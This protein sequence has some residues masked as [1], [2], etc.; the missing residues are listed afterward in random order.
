MPFS[1][2]NAAIL[3]GLA[4]GALPILIHLFSRRKVA[5]M[6]FSSLRFLEQISRRRVRRVRLTQWIILA[7]RVLAIVLLALALSRPAFRGDFALGK[8]R[9]ESAVA[10]IL[11]RSF[12]M[13]AAGERLTLWEKARARA[14]E[15]LAVLDTRDRVYLVGVDP[16]GDVVEVFPEPISARDALRSWEP[17]YGT[18]DLVAGLRRA[19]ETLAEA[20]ALNKEIFVI[21]DFQQ[22]AVR[23]ADVGSSDL[24]RDLDPE[25]RVFLLPVGE[26]PIANTA[27]EDARAEG[28]AVDQRIRVLLAR[29]GDTPA[30][31][32]ALTVESASEVLGEMT[33]SISARSRESGEVSLARLPG[34][35]EALSVRVSADRLPVDDRRYIPPL[36]TGRISVLVVQEP[37]QQSPFLP[38]AL[39]PGGDSDRFEVRRAAPD[40]MGSV[41]LREVNLIVLDNVTYLPREI[42]MRL[43]QWRAGG[44]MILISLGDRVD[45]RFYNESLLPALFPGV[46]LGNLLGTDEATATSYSLT[47]RAPGHTAFSGFEAKLGEPITG[48]T[49]WR[50]VEVKSESEVRTLAEFGPGLPAIVQGDGALLFASSLDGRWNNFPTHASFLP[51][52][53]QGVAS[54]MREAHGDNVRVGEAVEGVVDRVLVPSG[55]ELLCRGPEGLELEVTAESVVKGVLLRSAP[56]PVPGFYEMRAGDRI[57]F[58][59]A[60]NVDP[61]ESDLTP[62]S[63]ET[64]SALFPG[65]RVHLLEMDRS[66]R[67]PVREA[68]YGR[69]FWKELVAVVLLLAVAEAWL[70]RRGVA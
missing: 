18:T 10:V 24:T 48:A 4:A 40:A 8:S 17:G 7:M 34:E 62:L 37:A 66:V 43:R 28:T 41:D 68:R 67:S 19:G 12:S 2:L 44:G 69:E 6:P 3:T 60:V 61:G 15:V 23:G 54:L 64:L 27:I 49:F 50:I 65:E 13:A 35:G 59:R 1:F 33:L 29:H 21:S 53:H 57:L 51:L 22:S 25:T 45:L 70:G 63:T 36:G 52:L 14:E 56:A 20:T 46:S 47:P 32:V 42:L 39:S 26:G 5:R 16:L 9:G 38:L 31:D 58:R 11:D 30:D 55:A